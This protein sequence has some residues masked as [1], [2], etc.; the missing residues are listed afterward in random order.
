[1]NA[2]A[3]RVMSVVFKSFFES[4]VWYGTTLLSKKSLSAPVLIA[5]LM[6]SGMLPVALATFNAF[7]FAATTPTTSPL[8][9]KSGPP[10]LPGWTAALICKKR[11]SL[12][13]PLNELTFRWLP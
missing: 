4:E 8:E 2:L 7:N 1:M 9:A 13:I 5:K 10:L 12:K 11:V 3:L 6:F